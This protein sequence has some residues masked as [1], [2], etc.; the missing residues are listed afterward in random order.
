MKLKKIIQRLLFFVLWL[1]IGTGMIFLLVAAIGQ[2]NKE[3][4]RSYTISVRGGAAGS[5]LSQENIEDLLQQHTAGVRGELMS[6]FN[7]RTVESRLQQHYW[8]RKAQL[9]FDNQDVLH[10]Q[11][12][13][14]LPLARVFTVSGQSFYLDELGLPMPLAANKT[15]KLPVF[16]G[17]PD[18]LGV[19]G[20][21][22]ALLQEMRL[23]AQLIAADS[24][25][26]S[27]VAQLDRSADGSWE[28]IPLVGDHVVKLG[29]LD[30]IDMKF[31]RLWIFYTQVLSKTG[32]SR[33]RLVD[34]R[35]EGQVIAGLGTNPRID[36]V[37]LRRSV[38]Q[39]LQ[40][41]RAAENDTVVR[42]LPQ[43]LQPLL[44]D[45]TDTAKDIKNS[46]P[47]DSAQLNSKPIKKN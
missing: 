45:A 39:L 34:V 15:V 46:L 1:G 2:R 12:Q 43:P 6:R 38:Q 16:T 31:R 7:L 17:L 30:N 13:E 21:D 36:S 35:Y 41:S 8:I 11:I 42:Y 18:S 33:Y 19:K 24:F 20:K 29:S 37:Q 32:L 27:Q 14:K 26:T 44:P 3:R 28:L 47:V 23:A 25:W 40:Q 5:F 9:Y 4:L 22:S 10:V